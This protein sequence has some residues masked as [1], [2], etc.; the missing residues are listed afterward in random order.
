VT[1]KLRYPDFSIVTRRRTPGAIVTAEMLGPEATALFDESWD[2]R[3]LRL[4]GLGISNFIPDS[5]G[6]LSLFDGDLSP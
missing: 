2:G 4:M 1:L 3:P 5:P 6:Q